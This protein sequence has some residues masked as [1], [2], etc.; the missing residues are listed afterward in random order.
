MATVIDLGHRAGFRLGSAEVR[1][2]TCEVLGPGGRETIEPR[3]MQ[4]LVALAEARGETVT[5]D[6]LN[7]RCWAGRVVGNDSVNRAIFRIRQIARGVAAGSF[8]LRTIPKVG[9]RLIESTAGEG[10]AAPIPPRA[11]ELSRLAPASLPAPS[12][13]RSRLWLPIGIAAAGLAAVLIILSSLPGI[14]TKAANGGRPPG[15]PYDPVAI[16]LAQRG[17]A[18]SFEGTPAQTQQAIGYFRAAVDHAPGDSGLWGALALNYI[19]S[20]SAEPPERQ[21]PALLR[22]RQAIDRAITLDPHSGHGLAARAMLTRTFGNWTAKGALVRTAV[23]ESRGEEAAP[24]NQSGRLLGAVGRMTE[25][26]RDYDRAQTLHPLVPWIAIGR[27]EAF[28]AAGR[29]EE[30]EAAAQK[31][32]ELWPRNYD[33]WVA[34]FFLAMAGGRGDAALRMADDRAAWPGGARAS[35]MAVLRQAAEAAV[36]PTPA[37]IDAVLDAYRRIAPQGQSYSEQAIRVAALLGRPDSALDFAE[38]LYLPKSAPAVTRRF[39]DH[40]E[41]AVVGDRSTTPLFLAPVAR[42]WASPRFL[43]LM[44]KI[45]LAPYWRASGAPDFCRTAEMR[46]ACLNI[47]LR[48]G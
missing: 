7:E 40:V 29:T 21:G 13:R 2:T 15:T 19:F 20:A 43:P 8:E 35:D 27:I 1:P 3:V 9:Y 10:Q 46:A 48:I 39:D 25:S 42:L 26:L 36:T 14:S 24:L 18:S 28:A 6:D 5:R 23:A 41:Y 44:E 32:A 45:G 12:P 17:A 34:R 11:E 30:A 4:V 47:G 38:G 16:D 33:L 37:R 31:A 22:A